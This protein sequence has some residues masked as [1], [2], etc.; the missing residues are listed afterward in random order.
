MSLERHID[1]KALAAQAVRI[2]AATVHTC[3]PQDTRNPLD[4]PSLR[5]NMPLNP[6]LV[7][8]ELT[9]F[10]LWPAILEPD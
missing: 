3:L 7:S 9:G 4:S 5:D 8:R 10:Y 6:V 2:P 1:R